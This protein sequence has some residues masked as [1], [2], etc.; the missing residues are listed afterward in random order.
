M[1]HSGTA[2]IDPSKIFAKIQINAGARVADFGCGRTGHVVYLLSPLVGEKGVVY[3]VDIMKDVLESIK[4]QALSAG[5]SNIQTVWSDVESPGA[6]AIPDESLDAGFFMNVFFMLKN[7]SQAL[8][9]AARLIK[10]GGYLA[11]VDWVKKIG[12]LGPQEIQMINQDEFVKLAV[13]A[14]FEPFDKVA[15]GEYHFCRI[16]KKKKI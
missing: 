2:L 4:S 8:N 3:A 5:F 1:T 10:P 16:F 12:P 6:A 9:E 11:V 15:V 7:H 14:G 13:K